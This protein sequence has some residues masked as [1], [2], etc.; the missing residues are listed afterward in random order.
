[1]PYLDVVSSTAS[2][3][4]AGLTTANNLRIASISVAAYEFVAAQNNR[5]KKK[6]TLRRRERRP[7]CRCPGLTE[8]ITR[9]RR[10]GHRCVVI[11]VTGAT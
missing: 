1:M 3:G 6:K 7:Q 9:T 11:S 2:S 4:Q 8:E 5:L 10:S